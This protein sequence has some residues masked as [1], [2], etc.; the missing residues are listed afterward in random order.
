MRPGPGIVQLGAGVLWVSISPP[1]VGEL[2]R[3]VSVFQSLSVV[4]VTLRRHFPFLP[5]KHKSPMRHG[6]PE[7]ASA[8]FGTRGGWLR[9]RLGPQRAAEAR[10]GWSAWTRREAAR[11]VTGPHPVSFQLNPN[12]QKPRTGN[13]SEGPTPPGTCPGGAPPGTCP[14]GLGGLP[15][16]KYC[17]P[18][19]LGGGT[20][21]RHRATPGGYG[22]KP[23]GVAFIGVPT[24][25]RNAGS[26]PRRGTRAPI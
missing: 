10:M 17:E 6:G 26:V 9:G 19:G 16:D 25:A 15:P 21:S 7:A 13:V 3:V 18:A 8:G 22:G 2:F 24:G 12:A 1:T 5:T 11:L 23:P 4:P 20:P 14:G